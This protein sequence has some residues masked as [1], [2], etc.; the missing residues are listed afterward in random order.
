ML[1]R[2]AHVAHIGAVQRVVQDRQ[3]QF[4]ARPELMVDR[5]ARGTGAPRDG[6][7]AR[8]AH[9][10]FDDQIARGVD[11]A[12]SRLDDLNGTLPQPIR[13][14]HTSAYPLRPLTTYVR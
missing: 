10:C 2:L 6:V 3:Q 4:F 7:E 12:F 9:A 5:G 14:G 13:T 1:Q 8:I 11:D